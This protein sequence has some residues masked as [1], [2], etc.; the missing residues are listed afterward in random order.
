MYNVRVVGMFR[1]D[2]IV[3]HCVTII[4]GYLARLYF[5]NEK[6]FIYSFEY[7]FGMFAHIVCM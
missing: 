7:V 1:F 2:F 4:T 6:L 3:L 5:Q